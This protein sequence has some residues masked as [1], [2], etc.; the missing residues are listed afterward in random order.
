MNCDKISRQQI[1]DDYIHGRL[2]DE[3]REAFDAHC[4]ECDRCFNELQF[5]EEVIGRIREDAPVLFSDYLDQRGKSGPSGILKILERLAD[6]L[7]IHKARWMAAVG[8]L[9]L[10]V[11]CL[12]VFQHKQPVSHPVDHFKPLPY[13]EEIITDVYR[14]DSIRLISPAIGAVC[15]HEITFQWE[16]TAGETV[17]LIIL[18]NLGE[19]QYRETT[20]D[21]QWVCN[22]NL[23]PG[24]YYWKLETE[25][26]LLK[27]GKFLI[28]NKE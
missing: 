10:A 17:S 13:L 2:T 19:E 26:E 5:Y 14:S 3:E 24:L 15:D 22:K 23:S 1:I 20:S 9:S 28:R 18:N 7:M 11:L 4:F 8:T 21:Q 27:V 16:G 6:V 12:L 25:D